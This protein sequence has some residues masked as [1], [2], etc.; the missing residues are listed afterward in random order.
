[1]HCA[2]GSG[3]NAV[4][5]AVCPAFG[6]NIP[7][8]EYKPGPRII[9]GG[10][11]NVDFW[12][13]LQP[14]AEDVKATP[15]ISATEPATGQTDFICGALSCEY[16]KEFKP[17]VRRFRAAKNGVPLVKEPAPPSQKSP[18]T[19]CLTTDPKHA[20]DTTSARPE[21]WSNFI[22][23]VFMKTACCEFLIRILVLVGGGIFLV[24][25]KVIEQSKDKHSGKQEILHYVPATYA[26]P[27]APESRVNDMDTKYVPASYAD[28]MDTNYVPASYADDMD[29]DYVPATYAE[30]DAPESCVNDMNTNYSAIFIGSDV[31]N[32]SRYYSIRVRSMIDP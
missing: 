21:T 29:T 14:E 22:V 5:E 10:L 16:V 31:D 9:P 8:I 6:H 18:S 24:S 32:G 28:D 7:M 25:V 20:Q 17:T 2:Q 19:A 15:I 13:D 1:V 27:D 23:G 3:L 26:E 12:T 30:P 4:C 11:P